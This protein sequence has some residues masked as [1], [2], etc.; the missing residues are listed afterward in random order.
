[1]TTAVTTLSSSV[2]A[3]CPVCGRAATWQV[4]PGARS[5]TTHLGN[6]LA[7]LYRAEPRPFTPYL[8]TPLRR[9]NW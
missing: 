1:M 6:V 2:Q 9:G 8:P 3:L 5:C 4:G 7:D